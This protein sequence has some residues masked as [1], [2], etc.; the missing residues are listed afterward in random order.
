[1]PERRGGTGDAGIADEN[2]ELAMT[3]MQRRAKPGDAVEVGEVERHE[4]RAAAVFSD[5]VV[6]LFETPL[7]SRHRNHM[8][9]G[10]RQ[11]ARGGIADAARCAGDES[12]TGGEGCRHKTNS[13]QSSL[14]TQGPIRREGY[15]AG[16]WSCLIFFGERRPVVDAVGVTLQYRC[17]RIRL[18]RSQ[19]QYPS[20]NEIVRSCMDPS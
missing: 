14:R 3:L 11:R 13:P 6:E 16:R 5:L 18:L 12:D 20:V 9:A 2:V 8:R 17:A 7:C 4:R 15:D 10:F 1:M 19:T